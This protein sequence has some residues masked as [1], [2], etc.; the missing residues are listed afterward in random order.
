[1][2]TGWLHPV[3]RGRGVSPGPEWPWYAAEPV[4]TAHDMPVM[5]AMASSMVSAHSVRSCGARS[6]LGGRM[7]PQQQRHLC[8]MQGMHASASGS[9]SGSIT[10]SSLSTQHPL[11]SSP[12]VVLRRTPASRLRT[13]RG[14][15]P[16]AAA[17]AMNATTALDS[18]EALRAL[19][20]WDW[21]TGIVVA[22]GAYAWVKI[23]NHLASTGAMDKKLSR[24]LVHMTAGPLFMA[25]WVLFSE[26]PEARFIA[27]LVPSINL[28]RCGS[29]VLAQQSRLTI[30]DCRASILPSYMPCT[31]CTVFAYIGL[32]LYFA[33][34]FSPSLLHVGCCWLVAVFSKTLD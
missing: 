23:F 27:A 13:Q 11:L 1:V 3:Q 19:P 16:P 17:V 34:P 32:L 14:P 9:G 7:P 12:A 5:A 8:C 4:L 10:I 30:D 15:L 26:R 18:L 6:L 31:V 25:S 24:K 2:L 33:R 20:G 28:T 21:A 22:I 29:S